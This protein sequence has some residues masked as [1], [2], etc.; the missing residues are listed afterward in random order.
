MPNPAFWTAIDTLIREQPITID[1][2]KNTP[3]PRHKFIYPLDYGYLEGT[4][5]MDGGIDIW[6]GSL[7]EARCDAIICTVDLLKRD[8]EI[9]L[10]IG[11]NEGEKQAVLDFHNG[12]GMMKGILVRREEE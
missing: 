2:P 4:T 1:R 7:P 5:A 11:C 3:H 10:L 8:A 6:R 9:K 12:T